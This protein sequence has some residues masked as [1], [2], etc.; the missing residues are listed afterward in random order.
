VS[1]TFLAVELDGEV[2]LLDV[3]QARLIHLDPA[4]RRVWEACE[5]RTTA[6]MTATL[7]GPEQHLAEVL[8]SLAD[9]GVLWEEEGRWRRAS[10]R[11]VGPR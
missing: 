3:A 8:R 4:A 5:G 6:E 2:V 11:W 9:A 1:A 10:L 7:A